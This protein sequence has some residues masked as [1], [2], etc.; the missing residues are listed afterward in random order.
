MRIVLDTNVLIAAFIAHGTCNE[1]L[2]H[3]ALRHVVVLSNFILDELR[4][5]LS[6]KFGFNAAECR[7]VLA[8]LR[9]HCVFVQPVWLKSPGCSDPDDDVIIGTAVA[10]NCD[11]LV[12][13]DKALQKLKAYG[14]TVIVSPGDFWKFEE[15]KAKH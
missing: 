4:T 9:S 8:L 6:E 1:L 15:G 2:E 5:V 3:C 12:T 13:G 7:E 14:R 11:C 10:G